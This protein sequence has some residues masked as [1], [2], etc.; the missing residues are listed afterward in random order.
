MEK[1]SSAFDGQ[2]K[3]YPICVGTKILKN[4]A[5]M[6]PLDQA[7]SDVHKDLLNFNRLITGILTKRDTCTQVT[8][9]REIGSI[10]A[11]LRRISTEKLFSEKVQ[12]IAMVL[13][14]ELST[15]ATRMET[16]ADVESLVVNEIP[17]IAAKEFLVRYKGVEEGSTHC[18]E[19]RHGYLKQ[20]SSFR[21][22]MALECLLCNHQQSSTTYQLVT[23]VSS[24][25]TKQELLANVQSLKGKFHNFSIDGGG[26]R[27]LIPTSVLATCEGEIRSLDLNK[28]KAILLREYPKTESAKDKEIVLFVG[29]TGAGKT[30]TINYLLGSRM[31]VKERFGMSVVEPLEG[32]LKAD[33]GHGA[34]AMTLYP[35]VY[36]NTDAPLCYCDC[37]GFSDTSGPEESICTAIIIKRLVSEARTAKIVVVMRDT[38]LHWN[39]GTLFMNLLSMLSDLFPAE[40]ELPVMFVMNKTNPSMT[41]HRIKILLEGLFEEVSR[42]SIS[43]RKEKILNILR[44]V[45]SDTERY[46]KIIDVLDG[47][48]SAQGLVEKLRT[49]SPIRRGSFSFYG[50]DSLRFRFKSAI[51][52]IIAEMLPVLHD[53]KNIPIRVRDYEEQLAD[54]EKRITFYTSQMENCEA[55]AENEEKSGNVQLEMARMRESILKNHTEQLSLETE[56]QAL[57][58]LMEEMHRDTSECVLWQESFS[59]ILGRHSKRFIYPSHIPFTRYEEIEDISEGMDG[60]VMGAK[61]AF[62]SMSV[63]ASTG[64]R[65]I[66]RATASCPSF[67]SDAKGEFIDRIVDPSNGVYQST[68]ISK[69]SF[70]GSKVLIYG[71]R[72]QLPDIRQ[73]MQRTDELLQYKKN[74]YD[75]LVLQL[76]SMESHQRKLETPYQDQDKDQEVISQQKEEIERML[77]SFK[78]RKILMEK[79][80]SLARNNL[81]QAELIYARQLE[82]CKIVSDVVD[83]ADFDEF[84][85]F[86]QEFKGL[87]KDL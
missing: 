69:S 42:N 35:K 73:K 66:A 68:Y 86:V 8:V 32:S 85:P 27:S 14:P 15:L 87:Y 5:F 24:K 65:D 45:C 7:G 11:I 29:N 61:M 21:G 40:S 17:A 53:K 30:T 12:A 78:E 33:V 46:T 50:A 31:I 67:F 13:E 62:E 6:L 51:R 23:R 84:S 63:T 55:A 82:L 38:E 39:R 72:N 41:E 79:A 83:S 80:C 20:L 25:L 57:Q 10:V 4:L 58:Q 43:N 60:G 44:M 49:A 48:Q 54:I 18:E 36:E 64:L 81:E 22:Q 74:H 16:E 2:K 47:L 1:L 37:P 76:K 26:I 71:V 59:S 19:C 52:E 77:N 75:D 28:I 3:S 56:I 9:Q 34:T 70:L